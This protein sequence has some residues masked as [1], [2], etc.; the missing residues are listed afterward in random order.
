[1]SQNDPMI[2]LRKRLL[3]SRGQPPASTQLLNDDID[4]LQQHLFRDWSFAAAHQGSSN[5]APATEVL[6]GPRDEIVEVATP[7]FQGTPLS[8]VDAV[9]DSQDHH[10]GAVA[11][12]LAGL[13]ADMPIRKDPEQYPARFGL[14]FEFLVPVERKNFF[15]QPPEPGRYFIPFDEY[16]AFGVPPTLPAQ[17]YIAGILNNAQMP[18]VSILEE[19]E[20]KDS[21]LH[22]QLVS[23]YYSVWRVRSDSTVRPDATSPYKKWQLIGLEVNSP[24]LPA[25]ESGFLQVEKALRLMRGN[26]QMHL[27]TSSSLHVHVDT[28]PLTFPEM[29][30]FLSL[31]LMIEDVLF[32]FCAPH[33]FD[34]VWCLPTSIHSELAQLV[35]RNCIRKS[36]RH[37]GKCIP[38]GQNISS[39]AYEQQW[40]IQAMVNT[41]DMKRLLD[42]PRKPGTRTALAMKYVG[43]PGKS[44]EK[45]TFEFRHFQATLNPDLAREWARICVALVLAA[46][47]LGEYKQSL[48]NMAYNKFNQ[49]GENKD[50][51]EARRDLLTVLGLE[52]AVNFWQRQAL[53]YQMPDGWQGEELGSDGFAPVID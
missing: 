11:S 39:K 22:Q 19:F 3:E 26:V 28:S 41:R 37:R 51:G 15:P 23:D 48:A 27:S 16:N 40:I 25:D 32:S 38:R 20:G 1:M 4:R 2:N 44:E 6:Y 33:R 14:E 10:I 21:I 50:K 17:V 24:K 45:Y 36:S 9:G 35:S 49:I 53:T 12:W 43:K 30:H 52:D 34:H 5:T 7:S 18:A 47:G 46:K 29:Q 8:H 31:Y 42:Q 13:N